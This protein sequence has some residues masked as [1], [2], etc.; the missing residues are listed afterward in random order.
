MGEERRAVME[1]RVWGCAYEVRLGDGPSRAAQGES[2]ALGGW[3]MAVGG[4]R[5]AVGGVAWR[6][7]EPLGALAMHEAQRRVEGSGRRG[8]D[9]DKGRRRWMRGGGGG[10]GAE[11]ASVKYGSTKGGGRCEREQ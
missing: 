11:R 9:E 3:R 2:C 10:G 4:G 6:R 5:W 8:A 1:E 7:K